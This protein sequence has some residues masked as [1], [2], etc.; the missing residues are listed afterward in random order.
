MKKADFK[1]T[2]ILI[3][4]TS[5]LSTGCELGSKMNDLEVSTP[6]YGEFRS[7]PIHQIQPGGWLKKYLEN[8]K[9]GLTGHLE[10]AGY[11][12]DTA[13]WGKQVTDSSSWWPYEQTGYWID[14]MLSTGYLL[15][16]SF[17]LQKAKNRIY[18]VLENVGEDHFIGPEYLKKYKKKYRWVHAVYFR[19][20]MTEYLVTGNEELLQKIRQFHLSQPLGNYLEIRDQLNIENILWA[21]EQSGDSALYRLALGIYD[22]LNYGRP[23]QRPVTASSFLT[24]EPVYEHGVTYNEVAKLGAILYM[25]NGDQKYLTPSIA[26]FDKLDKYYM[27]V[28][29]VN[30][31][32]EHLRTPPDALQTHETCDIADYTWSI[33]Y[34]LM[35]TGESKYA[36]KIEKAIFNAAPGAVTSDFKALQYLSGPNQVVLDSTSNHNK[37][38]KGNSAM[39]FGPNEFTEC[40]PGNVNRIMPNYVSRLWMTD[41]NNGVVAAMFGPSLWSGDIKGVNVS[42]EEKTRY[43]FSDSVTFSFQTGRPVNFPFSFRIPEWCNEAE[44]RI[45]GK[46]LKELRPQGK[47]VSIDRKF[48][49]GDQVTV[50]LPQKIKLSHWPE[51]GVAIERG[52]LVYSLKIEENRKPVPSRKSNTSSMGDFPTFHLEA[53]SEWNYALA[54]DE[55]RLEEQIEVEYQEWNNDPWNTDTTPIQ[56]HV[57]ARKVPGW[58]LLRQ[59]TVFYAM[60][61]PHQENGRTVWREKSDF[62]K[63]GKFSFT[64][65]L[66]PDSA[67]INSRHQPL[68]KVILVPYG[69]S[70]LRITIFPVVPQ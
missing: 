35:A 62:R 63:N 60:N 18:P 52:P 65:P 6:F 25:N 47:Y 38:F 16:D 69:S 68:E 26:A 44:V 43:P 39:M 28:D 32:S 9:N 17:L 3:V 40:C 41:G 45:N 57:P 8:Q 37:F 51:K 64:P 22:S 50:I 49:D 24:M 53:Q 15:R 31:S 55:D 19:A 2:Y 11:P 21:F 66:P 34:L 14:G 7:V 70:K 42:I 56:L 33:G 10:H 20:L 36:D 12:F 4:L 46:P 61:V 13:G 67:L 54:V 58:K 30:V 5:F 23:L 1:P 27:M 59:D 29:G 48:S